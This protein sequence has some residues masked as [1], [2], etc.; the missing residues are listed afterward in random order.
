M[1][2]SSEYLE[3]YG[4]SV[5]DARGFIMDHLGSPLTIFNAAKLYGVTNEMLGEIIGVST[6][7]VKNFWGGFG[8]AYTE[9]DGKPSLPTTY[10][11][12]G[13]TVWNIEIGT[14]G[15]DYFTHSSGKTI[16]LG[17]GGNDTFTSILKATGGAFFVG[18]AGDD[19]YFPQPSAALTFI[20]DIGGGIDTLYDYDYIE[21][22]TGVN[23]PESVPLITRDF[24]VVKH[25]VLD[26]CQIAECIVR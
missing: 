17:M 4:I 3:K 5:E 16:Y 22:V 14:P 23:L 13:G 11:S 19:T 26:G 12:A 2:L 9:L 25:S 21:G 6:D 1:S 10:T 18:G 20:K 15:N 8:L 24:G 7:A